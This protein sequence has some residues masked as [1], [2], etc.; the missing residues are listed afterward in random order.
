MPQQTDPII[1]GQLADR[2]QQLYERHNATRSS[3]EVTENQHHQ[4]NPTQQLIGKE[5]ILLVCT[6]KQK[7][8]FGR[9]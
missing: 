7:H 8:L 5:G 1:L 2:E 6:A 3:G 9:T 4:L